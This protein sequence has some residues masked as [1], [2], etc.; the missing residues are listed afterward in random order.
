LDGTEGKVIAVGTLN[1]DD[2]AI[3]AFLQRDTPEAKE[4]A[5]KAMKR[6]AKQVGPD[7]AIKN[8]PDAKKATKTD[9]NPDQE[10]PRV[11][12]APKV[13]PA[14]RKATDKT[15]PAP[16]S[17]SPKRAKRTGDDKT[18]TA[19]ASGGKSTI[20]SVARAAILAGK[21]NDEALAMVMGAF[22]DCSSNLGCMAWYRNKLKKEGYLKQ[23]G[24]AS[25]KSAALLAQAAALGL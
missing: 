13:K 25:A 4:Q 24:T 1:G 12:R 10:T 15:S 14:R 18:K 6:I 22:P 20:G 23:N 5:K 17:D 11:L 2:L 19:G 7:R 21:T 16:V 8:P 9:I 3:P